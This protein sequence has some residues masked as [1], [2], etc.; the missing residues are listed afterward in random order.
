LA[1]LA[2]RTSGGVPAS[3]LLLQWVIVNV[4]L[5]TATF[6]TVVNYVQFSLTL[7]SALTVLGV[8]VLRWR[9][10]NLE[11]PFRAWGYPVTPL[12]FLAVS[13][14]MMWH[15]LEDPSTRWPSLLGLATA[16]SGLVLYLMSPKGMRSYEPV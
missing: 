11:R 1:W 3:A 10:P 5:L 8:Y 12:I 4:M 7:C 2:R 14:W 16:L 15:L 6:Q 13:G 9:R